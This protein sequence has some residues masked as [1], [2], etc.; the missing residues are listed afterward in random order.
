MTCPDFLFTA[1]AFDPDREFDG[2]SG[3]AYGGPDP[4]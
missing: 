1:T 3:I 2:V 4:K